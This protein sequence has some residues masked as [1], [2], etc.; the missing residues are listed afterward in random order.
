M[1]I[2]K[3]VR[4]TGNVELDASLGRIRA[5]SSRKKRSP[6]I[7]RPPLDDAQADFFVPALYDTSPRDDKHMMD[8][9]LFRLSKDKKRAGE[10]IRYELADGHVEVKA[11]PDGMASIWDYDIVLMMISHLTEAMNRYRDGSGTMPG[12][13]FRPHVNDILKFCRKG[14]GGNQVEDVESALARLQGTIIKSVRIV[15]REGERAFREVRSEGL[16]SSHSVISRTTTGNVESVEIEAPNWIYQEITAG[17]SPAVLTV[18]PDYFLITQGISRFLYRL[19]RRRAMKNQAEW[20]FRTIY[21]RS[22]SAGEFKE[23]CR[24]IRNAIKANNLPEY[25][26][27]EKAGRGG[28]L[29]VMRFRPSLAA[30]TGG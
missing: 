16:I 25:D 7:R 11:G 24:L 8:V 26:L 4:K 28:P 6:G 18:H 9:A 19:A 2:R 1:T 23:F 30:P 22:G 10:V 21:E 13:T 27:Q 5:A 29:L 3:F 20:L 17:K 12:R 15:E 14:R